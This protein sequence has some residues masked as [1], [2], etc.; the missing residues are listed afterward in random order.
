MRS[1]DCNFY[2]N[3]TFGR[4]IDYLFVFF[5]P[6]KLGL[7]NCGLRATDCIAGCGSQIAGCGLRAT[8]RLQ[9]AGHRLRAVGFGTHSDCGLRA[10][11]CGLLTNVLRAAGHM[12][13][14]ANIAGG[15]M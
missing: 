12:L 6:Q 4:R 8:L 14:I 5:G 15:Y 10:T 1:E 13:W 2:R 7:L 3:Q 11:D 9:A